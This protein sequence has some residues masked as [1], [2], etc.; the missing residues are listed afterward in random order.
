MGLCHSADAWRGRVDLLLLRRSRRFIS[1]GA[2]P[3]SPSCLRSALFRPCSWPARV[4]FS[5]VS[6]CM[7]SRAGREHRKNRWRT[8]A[9]HALSAR[10]F[11]S[12]EMAASRSPSN[13]FHPASRRSSWQPSRFTWLFSPGGTGSRPGR[14]RLS[15]SGSPEDSRASRF[16]SRRL[17]VFRLTTPAIQEPAS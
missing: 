5:P 1:S 3:I 8:G 17:C 9:R 12:E 13:T 10:V 6:S 4:F 15:G 11:C 2:Q 7:R 14:R 16:S